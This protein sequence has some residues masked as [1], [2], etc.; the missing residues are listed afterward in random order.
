[1]ECS[2]SRHA[3]KPSDK[4]SGTKSPIGLPCFYYPLRH[5]AAN[6][7]GPDRDAKQDSQF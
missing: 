1:V 6:H 4:A 2:V 7:F 5:I 3:N